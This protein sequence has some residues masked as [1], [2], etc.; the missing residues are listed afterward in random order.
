MQN[1]Y[2]IRVIPHKVMDKGTN[3]RYY[4]YD[5][6]FNERDREIFDTYE[7]AEK[8]LICLNFRAEAAKRIF[9]DPTFHHR[10]VSLEKI[11]KVME[12]SPEKAEAI[13]DHYRTLS[14]KCG[15]RKDYEL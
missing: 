1:Y 9:G 6:I 10:L 8:E 5:N 14:F 15:K 7:D 4:I 2:E 11:A 12:V 13:L 3:D